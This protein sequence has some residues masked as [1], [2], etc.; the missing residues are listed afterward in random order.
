M[1]SPGY[2][3]KGPS[4]DGTSVNVGVVRGKARVVAAGGEVRDVVFDFSF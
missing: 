1:P 2:C 3:E 4:A